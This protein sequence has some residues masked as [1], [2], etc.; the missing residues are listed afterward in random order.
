MILVSSFTNFS[1]LGLVSDEVNFWF[2]GLC[3][4]CRRY[5]DLWLVFR[6]LDQYV[7]ERLLFILRLQGYHRSSWCRRS[8]RFNEYDFVM[9]L[10]CGHLNR[11]L[12]SEFLLLWW[13]YVDV[14]VFLDYATASE[15]T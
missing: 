6:L 7:D 9:F 1:Y 8:W 2:R 11:P 3:G 14:Y 13:R 4:C 5:A 15:T 10:G 12:W